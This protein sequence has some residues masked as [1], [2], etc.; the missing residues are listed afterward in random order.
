MIYF[1]DSRTYL[2]TALNKIL[3]SDVVESGFP[4]RMIDRVR[5]QICKVSIIS[6][7]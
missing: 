4:C 2:E 5:P 1:F 3:S 7:V 6:M